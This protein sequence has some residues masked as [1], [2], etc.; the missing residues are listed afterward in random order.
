MSPERP[1][2]LQALTL[3]SVPE[4]PPELAAIAARLSDL[5]AQPAPS[6]PDDVP[7]AP[8]VDRPAL[9]RAMRAAEARFGAVTLGRPTAGDGVKVATWRLGGPRG[10][11]SLELESDGAGGALTRVAFV[12]ASMEP[13]ALAD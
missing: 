1:P 3:T 13:P 6:W 8:A 9:E 7:L 11:L 5:L 4:P 2:R 12:P 10:D